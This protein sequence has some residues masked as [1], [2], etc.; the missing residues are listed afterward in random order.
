M[1]AVLISKSLDYLQVIELKREGRSKVGNAQYLILCITH[2]FESKA[3]G[4]VLDT[5]VVVNGCIIQESIELVLVWEIVAKQKLE[6][7]R[8]K[9]CRNCCY[10]DVSQAFVVLIIECHTLIKDKRNQE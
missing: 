4:F 5:E 10:Q 1:M 6:S 9:R 8:Y 2:V 7:Q 3:Q